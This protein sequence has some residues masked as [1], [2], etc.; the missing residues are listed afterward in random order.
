[1]EGYYA[2]GNGNCIQVSWHAG[3][4]HGAAAVLLKLCWSLPNEPQPRPSISPH[5]PHMQCP[6][7][8]C[9]ECQNVT[10]VCLQ[11]Q[12]GYGYVDGA[13]QKCKQ[14]DRVEQ[15]DEGGGVTMIG[16]LCEK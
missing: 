5:L 9:T 11:C 15:T 16:P 13:C 6:T 14:G 4:G 12:P 7:P 3:P 8:G 1:M 2:D 10:G